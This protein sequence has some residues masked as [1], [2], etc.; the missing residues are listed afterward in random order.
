MS[1]QNSL[2]FNL[3]VFERM[4]KGAVILRSHK[5]SDHEHAL[6]ETIYAN[7][8]FFEMLNL[9]PHQV[10][11]RKFFLSEFLDDQQ[12]EQLYRC[13][14]EGSATQFESFEPKHKSWHILSV[15]CPQKPYLVIM[16]DDITQRRQLE[17]ELAESEETLRMT[18]DIAGEG[19]WEWHYDED[20]I[21]HNRRWAKTLGLPED[22]G[23]HELDFFMNHVHPEDVEKVTAIV[24]EATKTEQPYFSEHRMVLD[25]G[26]VI[27]IEDRGIPVKDKNGKLYRMIGS[28]TDTTRYKEIQQVLHLEKEII[29]STIL[30][31]GDGVITIDIDGKID[32][33]NPAA[34]KLTGW[35]S[36][37]V[38]GKQ[39]EDYFQLIE[40]DF[41]DQAYLL[42]LMEADEDAMCL[43]YGKDNMASLKNREGELI[44]IYYNFSPI[45]LP[46]GATYG[47]VIVFTDV[48]EIIEKQKQIEHLSFRDDLTG[49]YNRHYLKDAMHH[50]DN[51][52]MLPFTI[53]ILDLNELKATNDSFGHKEGDR[54][55]QATANMLKNC[56]RQEDVIA[57]MGGDEF[58]VLLPNT[59]AAVA[60][61]IKQ[62]IL[63]DSADNHDCKSTLSL[64]VG[65]AVKTHE[66]ES[67]DNTL[68]QADR[69]MY[70]HKWSQRTAD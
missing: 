47:Y 17:E 65:Y 33:F 11:G 12:Q 25:D 26:S 46:D 67:I 16:I 27:W 59:S 20:L 42:E 56:F 35:K 32:I 66:A 10:A 48:S 58:C 15:Y 6:Y 57:R 34:E 36:G 64:S 8:C 29:Q 38:K 31:V 39:I 28:L 9:E 70:Q 2:D 61:S 4:N 50:L 63:Q 53:M 30:S 14:S 7:P 23:S 52:R 60:E 1:E 45:R 43:K 54:L 55:I 41:R 69:N 37:E 68:T 49:L 13:E 62:R 24:E 51:K 18:L 21:Y 3:L 5:S 22:S 40:S 44:D 19:L